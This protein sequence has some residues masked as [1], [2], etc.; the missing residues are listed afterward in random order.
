MQ[1]VLRV[2][3]P[4][5]KNIKKNNRTTPKLL[6]E[7]MCSL[8]CLS[9]HSELGYLLHYRYLEIDRTDIPILTSSISIMYVKQMKL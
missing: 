2:L 6:P 5:K 1:G 8:P 3:P 7:A 4:P 9:K